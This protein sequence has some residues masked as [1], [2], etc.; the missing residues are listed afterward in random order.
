MNSSLA[1]L[2]KTLW[3]PEVLSASRGAC[4]DLADPDAQ[5]GGYLK[6][7][8]MQGLMCTAEKLLGPGHELLPIDPCYK[9]GPCFAGICGSR[10]AARK[11]RA[12][13]ITELRK[14]MA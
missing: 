11:S 1:E 5:G 12:Q 2:Q 14:M 6:A 7:V 10:E 8:I 4:Q 9:H 3:Q 13:V